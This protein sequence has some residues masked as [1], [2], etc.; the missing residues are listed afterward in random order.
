MFISNE[1]R[2]GIMFFIGLVLLILLIVTMTRWGKL[3]K[4]S[5]YT[6][7]FQQAQ[8]LQEG[9]AVYVAGVKVGQVS[10]VSFNP[11]TKRAQVSVL[12]EKRIRL[13]RN[14]SYTIGIGGLVGERFIDIRTIATDPG[15]LVPSGGSIAGTTT[16]DMN[17]VICNANTIITGFQTTVNGLNAIV[18]NTQTQE[19]LRKAAANLNQTTA[20]AAILTTQLNRMVQQNQHTITLM[21]SDIEDIAADLRQVSNALTPQ[22]AKSKILP[23]L[24][25]AA[26]NSVKITDRLASI[27]QAAETLIND[28]SLTT[29]LR[30]TLTNLQQ[31]SANLNQ[32]IA[33]ARGT[34]ATFP[35][36]SSNLQQASADL[37]NITHPLAEIAPETAQNILQV[38]RSLRTASGTLG[39]VAQQMTKIGSELAS[40]DVEPEARL[41][42]FIQS[43]TPMRSDLNLNVRGK[44][45]MV[46]LGVADIGHNSTLNL[47]FGSKIDENLWFRYGLVQSRF[48]LGADYKF[49]D[50]LQIAGELFDPNHA[51]A[52]FVIDN[53]LKPLG[54]EWWLSVGWYDLFNRGK[55]GV[56]F[57]YR[58]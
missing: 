8:G 51:R 38:S 47:Q 31:A 34:M 2:V 54:K 27:T 29:N 46:R 30:D 10:E 43:P 20:N 32:V 42:G 39:G 50:N 3:R 22:L 57:T 7:V 17:D 5:A 9:A 53:R 12:I 36:L 58:P 26:S 11:V 21:V 48:G 28:K 41:L 49:N 6:L 1:L 23:N 24:E 52:N 33:D 55:L 37:P 16:P 18:G 4:G 45:S 35:Q 19:N 14:Y 25:L 15:A 13:Y 40:L 56:G 44:S